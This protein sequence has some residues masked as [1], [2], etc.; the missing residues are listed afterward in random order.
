MNN[1]AFNIKKTSSL[2]KISLHIFYDKRQKSIV[3]SGEGL[4]D[5]AE[6]QNYTF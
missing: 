1:I 6:K 5:E 4:L 3:W 2:R